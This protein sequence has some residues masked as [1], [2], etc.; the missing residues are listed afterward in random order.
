VNEITS[1]LQTRLY[2][3]GSRWREPQL[4]TVVS[5]SNDNPAPGLDVCVVDGSCTFDFTDSRGR[6]GPVTVNLPPGYGHADQQDRRY[7]VIFMLHGYGQTPEDLGA[8]IIFINNWMNNPGDSATSRMPKSILVY[9]DGR[10]R[11]DE[12]GKA[13]C[14][15]GNFFTDSGREEG[16]K[17]E[18]WWLE[19]MTE[20]DTR[21]RTMGATET[22]WEE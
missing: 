7:P 9:V 15:R 22:D 20:I 6:K 3:I 2:F 21:Y 16:M 5:V 10:C 14:I 18:A 19:L 11:T 4:R 12:N 13:E 8:A 1:R 17:A